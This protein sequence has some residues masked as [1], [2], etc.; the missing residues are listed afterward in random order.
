MNS[1]EVLA[2]DLMDVVCGLSQTQDPHP[3]QHALIRRI[4]RHWKLH[5]AFLLIRRFFLGQQG[6]NKVSGFTQAERLLSGI[7][8]V[9]QVPS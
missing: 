7:S 2:T 5:Q 6:M 9:G 4:A 8:A 1:T 3:G